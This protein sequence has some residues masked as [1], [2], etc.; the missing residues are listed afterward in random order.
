MRLD[1]DGTGRS[2]QVRS[3]DGSGRDGTRLSPEF[4]SEERHSV[5]SVR[6]SDIDPC[7]ILCRDVLGVD[8]DK[9]L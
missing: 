9:F 8:V 7:T 5:G 4:P 2:G 1:R 6:D 3:K